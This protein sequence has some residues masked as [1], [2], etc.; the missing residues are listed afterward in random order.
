MLSGYLHLIFLSL[1]M[2]FGA[3]IAG[4]LPLMMTMS[5]RQLHSVNA[6]GCGLLLG[7]A[8]AVI[9]P[10]GIESLFSE[11]HS[12]IHSILESDNHKNEKDE[13]HHHDHDDHDSDTDSDQHNDDDDDDHA[14]ESLKKSIVGVSLLSG[15]MLMLLVDNIKCCGGM[16][17]HQHQQL[18]SSEDTERVGS[19]S[20]R[21]MQNNSPRSPRSRFGDVKDNS[22][23][24]PD[25]L[26]IMKLA[27]EPPPQSRV[28]IARNHSS[29]ASARHKQATVTI[30]LV[31]HCLADGLALGS[32]KAA[33][34]AASVAAISSSLSSSDTQSIPDTG[35]AHHRP[36]SNLDLIVFFAIM[37]HKVPAAFSYTVYLRSTGLGTSSIRKTLVLFASAAPTGALVSYPLLQPGFLVD[38]ANS[39]LLI[40]FFILFSAGTFLYIS[41]VHI[42]QEVKENSSAFDEIDA[43]S[44]KSCSTPSNSDAHT[45]SH[46]HGLESSD[47][48]QHGKLQSTQLMLVLV[49]S[50]IPFLLTANS[51]HSHAHG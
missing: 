16:H 28:A 34:A 46:S 13:N 43:A 38:E 18:P 32:A 49:G 26:E 21:A 17:L 14:A 45:H 3:F 11:Q 8:F 51:L 29:F 31:V 9:I 7:T 48:H 10:E 27:S 6:L 2:F 35:V 24:V 47:N 50:C 22:I 25:D 1:A 23:I 42:L 41:A 19:Q 5:Q 15:F 37:L 12:H 20:P 39:S 36:A 4:N 40:G 33:T 30:G 44:K